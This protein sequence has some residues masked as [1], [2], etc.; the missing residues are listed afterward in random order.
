MLVD[1]TSKEVSPTKAPSQEDSAN[2]SN[3]EHLTSR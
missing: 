2:E 3:W 1:P